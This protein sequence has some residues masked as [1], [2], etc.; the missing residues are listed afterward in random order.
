MKDLNHIGINHEYLPVDLFNKLKEQKE[1]KK[2]KKE[3]VKKEVIKKEVIKK[4]V[5][6]KDE[7]LTKMTGEIK[8]VNSKVKETITYSIKIISGS[9]N[10]YKEEN[11]DGIKTMTKDKILDELLI[12]LYKKFKKENPEFKLNIKIN[13]KEYVKKFNILITKYNNYVQK[14]KDYNPS[15]NDIGLVKIHKELSDNVDILEIKDNI[16]LILD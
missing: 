15:L 11:K 10:I 8:I 1:H 3:V 4:E 5:V 7:D 9:V 6:K 13:Y 14:A 16:N 12:K 2:I